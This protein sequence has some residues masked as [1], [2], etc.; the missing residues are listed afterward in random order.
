M[1]SSQG[2]CVFLETSFRIAL[3]TVFRSPTIGTSTLMI[4]P[5]SEGSMST[6]IFLEFL[7]NIEVFPV[8]RSSKRVPSP[9][10]RSASSSARLAYAIPC[11]PGHPPYKI[12]L[13]G[14]LLTPISVLITGIWAFSAN[15]NNSF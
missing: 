9:I 15:S 14:K 11:I 7:A 12:W 8:I 3:I 1:R 10:I 2:P 6:C 4:L 13:L 5:I